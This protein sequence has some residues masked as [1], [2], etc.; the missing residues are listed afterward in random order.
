MLRSLTYNIKQGFTQIF[1]NRGMSLASIF[2]ITA[3][4]LI[5]GLFFVI[6]VNVNMFTEA[7]KQDY[8]QIE[9]FLKDDTSQEEIMNIMSRMKTCDG[10]T[11]VEYRTKDEALEIMK[12]RWGE[13]GYLLDTLGNNPLPSSILITVDS[14]DNAGK[15]AEYAGSFE[16]VEDIQYYQE[17]VEKLTDIT[18]FLQIA[19]LIIMGFLV[20]VSVVVVSNTVK[21]TVFARAKEIRIMKYIGATNWFIRGPFLA[22]G[23]LIG[24][25]ASIV[26]TGLIALIYGK[27]VELI[28]AQVLAIVSCPLI[29]VS[30]LTTNMVIIFLAL[31]MSIGAWG[32]I[33]SMRR[34]LDT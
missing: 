10:V 7:V 4:L 21:L 15:V 22:E 33:V 3:M 13:S 26:A 20:V 11:E 23:I 19:A 30:Y 34:F 32:S 12:Q 8:D 29:S 24:M 28:G 27:I 1:R 16:N 18:N 5:L 14:L 31:G 2:S 25:L 17:T 9:V 6:M